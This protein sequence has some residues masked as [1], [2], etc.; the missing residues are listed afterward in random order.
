MTAAGAAEP[1]L[2][3]VDD[4]DTFR[5]VMGRALRSRGYRVL[6][7]ASYNDAVIILRVSAPRYAVIDLRMP[8]R[9]GLELLRT[10]K[11][12]RPETRVVV[13]S[14]NRSADLEAEATGLGAE[15][16]LAKPLDADELVAA[17]KEADRGPD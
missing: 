10:I 17:L 1:T 13:L 14:G 5:L 4:D 11:E 8:G 15:K 2:L 16:Y 9:S 12:L 6:E 3:L 7:A